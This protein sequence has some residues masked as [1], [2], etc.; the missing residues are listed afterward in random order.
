MADIFPLDST[1]QLSLHQYSLL[2]SVKTMHP[3][4]MS[5]LFPSEGHLQ[6]RSSFIG[7]VSLFSFLLSSFFFSLKVADEFEVYQHIV[8]GRKRG[9]ASQVD[10]G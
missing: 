10:L 5:L 1:R 7:W 3:I 4:Q 2:V 6:V 9:R 8:G